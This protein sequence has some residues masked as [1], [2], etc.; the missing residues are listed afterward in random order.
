MLTEDEKE[1]LECS[2]C[3]NSEFAEHHKVLA[4]GLSRREAEI[5]KLRRV[6]EAARDVDMRIV[7]TN[8]VEQKLIE[9][10]AALYDKPKGE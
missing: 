7:H 2:G 3:I 9:V 6:V 10:L 1:V 5:K 4:F 8:E